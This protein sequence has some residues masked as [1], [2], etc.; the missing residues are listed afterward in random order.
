MPNDKAA[1]RMFS[2]AGQD[3]FDMYQSIRKKDRTM[4]LQLRRKL[5]AGLMDDALILVVLLLSGQICRSN[6]LALGKSTLALKQ[7]DKFQV[8][9][10]PDLVEPDKPAKQK[11]KANKFRDEDHMTH[12]EF[13]K[14]HKGLSKRPESKKEA[15]VVQGSTSE[16]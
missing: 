12:D 9:S 10:E 14:K 15:K 3:S 1:S 2:K 5:A 8:Q 11:R 7:S 13:I 4:D 16:S 6:R